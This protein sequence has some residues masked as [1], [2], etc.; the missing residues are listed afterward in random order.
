MEDTNSQITSAILQTFEVPKTLFFN[1]AFVP[2]EEWKEI[3]SPFELMEK[4]VNVFME[5]TYNYLEYMRLVYLFWLNFPQQIF[6]NKEEISKSAKK[7][8][9]S[10]KNSSI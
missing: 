3:H 4:Q 8:K 6:I 7:L 9:K 5:N 1:F 10:I 2:L